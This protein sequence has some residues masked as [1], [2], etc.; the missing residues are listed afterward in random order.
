[1]SKPEPRRRRL[2]S[3]AVVQSVPAS[4]AAVETAAVPCILPPELRGELIRSLARLMVLRLLSGAPVS[5]A[6]L[7]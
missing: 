6:P 7:A 4:P 3:S 2:A 1:M 5:G